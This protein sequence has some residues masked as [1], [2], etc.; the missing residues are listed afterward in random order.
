[1]TAF[2][3]RLLKQEQELPTL[4][5]TMLG[6]S[7]V[8]KTSLLAA[9][10]DQFENVSQD[11]Q[12]VA[13][14]DSKPILKGRLEELKHL[15][16]SNSIKVG[17]GVKP[18]VEPRSFRFELGE[19]GT[20]ASLEINFQDYPGEYLEKPG[21]LEEVKG[22]IRDSAAVL[23]PIDTPP[24]ME[25]DGQY[26]EQFNQPSEL[27]YLFKKVY[28]D[29]DSPRLVI[30]V[31]VR[32]EKYMQNTSELFKKVK[33]G[34]QKTLNQFASD[35]LLPKVAV[36]IAP[37]QTVGNV[38]FS[39]FEKDE[40]NELTPRYRKP[41][42]NAPYQPKNTEVPLRCL[43]QF[44]VELHLDN[45]PNN[46]FYKTFNDSFKRIVS[47]RNAVSRLPVP[48]PDEVEIVQGAD[49]LKL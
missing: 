4:N 9:M 23:I 11:L 40:N 30:L 47:L 25:Q 31:P 22:F 46:L 5:V 26:H 36:A 28:K 45:A 35:K 13:D 19:T 43:L 6:P 48:R 34:Y 10:Y 44:L 38:E 14:G 1:M 32:C 15:L 39:R 41:Q 16:E 24:L 42:P 21:K 17:D 29:L 27:N 8:G 18:T 20:T 37:V 49:L 7:G 12:L 3:R 33:E 2:L